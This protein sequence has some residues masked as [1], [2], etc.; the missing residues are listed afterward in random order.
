MRIHPI[1]FLYSIIIISGVCIKKL[2]AQINSDTT[3]LLAS[4]TKKMI[5]YKSSIISSN[6]IFPES[7]ED[8]KEQSLGYIEKFSDQKRTYLLRT[9]QTGKKYFP[10]IVAILNRY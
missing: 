1:K 7:L 8:S 10:K 2:S 3:K 5:E 4:V 6:V 9:Y